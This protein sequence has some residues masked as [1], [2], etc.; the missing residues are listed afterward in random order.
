MR[1]LLFLSTAILAGCLGAT[2]DAGTPTGATDLPLPE[3][4]RTFLDPVTV[5]AGD[6]SLFIGAAGEPNLAVAPD[7]TRYVGILGCMEGQSIG[8]DATASCRHGLVYRSLDGASWELLNRGAD[9]RL[10]DGPFANGDTTVAVTADAVH[11]LLLQD[12]SHHY[13]RSTDRGDTWEYRGPLGEGDRPWLAASPDGRLVSSWIRGDTVVVSASDDQGE[14]WT[15]G[16]VN[17]TASRQGRVVW[18]PACGCFL[19]PLM[20]EGAGE[21]VINGDTELVHAGVQVFRSA[22]GVTWDLSVAL[23]P[24]PVGLSGMFTGDS[25][26]ILPA[27]GQSGDG[28]TAVAWS[29]GVGPE[30]GVRTAARIY[31]AV[32][33]NATTWGPV[34][35]VTPEESAVLPA[36]AG[37]REL[38]LAYY[39]SPVPGDPQRVGVW[40]MRAHFLQSGER[41]VVEEGVHHGGVCPSGARCAGVAADRSLFDFFEASPLPDG[42]VALAYAADPATQGKTA[43]VHYAEQSPP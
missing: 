25:S 4:P 23:D 38:V 27:V 13:H 19:M 28:T 39:S 37:G 24:Y 14:T 29:A 7:G 9:R 32:G 5:L 6:T 31:L 34:E 16:T 11:V 33:H 26:F 21:G 3:L 10:G 36:L 15:R 30:P 42:R 17:T 1:V 41:L 43:Q 18:G 20:V 40:S 12:G 22:D 35:D 2:P 8:L